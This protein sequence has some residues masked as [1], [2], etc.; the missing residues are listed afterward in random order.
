LTAT[1]EEQEDNP[2]KNKPIYWDL[3]LT[4]PGVLKSL[5]FNLPLNNLPDMQSRENLETEYADLEESLSADPE[6]YAKIRLFQ[7]PSIPS[8]QYIRDKDD[9]IPV[10]LEL[11][12]ES[13]EL[14]VYTVKINS[15]KNHPLYDY[16]SGQGDIVSHKGLQETIAAYLGSVSD[17]EKFTGQKVS[18]PESPRLISADPSSLI[19]D[20]AKAG[21]VKDVIITGLA[22]FIRPIDGTVN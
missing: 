4:V 3:M 15:D 20:P 17:G 9:Q 18:Y 7:M 6:D 2:E 8:A 5:G 16:Q 22:R 21:Y 19:I 13:S 14:H 10:D 1:C 12:I 11:M